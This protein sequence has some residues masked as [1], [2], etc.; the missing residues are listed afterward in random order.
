MNHLWS[1]WMAALRRRTRGTRST[2]FVAVAL[3]A[4][5]A[6]ASA[7]RAAGDDPA[8]LPCSQIGPLGL[9]KQTNIR[10]GL[11]LISCGLAA[12]GSSRAAG[13]SAPQ[14]PRSPLQLG[15]SDV[16]VVTGVEPYPH[17]TQAGDQTWANGSTVVAAYN[18]TNTASSNYSGVSYSTDGGASFT[19]I[20]PS[21]FA[22]GHGTNFGVPSVVFDKKLGTW[23]AGFLATGCG[24]QGLGLW[25]SPDGITWS[26]GACAH[27]GTQDD[28]P[29]MWVDNTPASPFY[30]RIYLTYNDFNVA[31]GALFATHSD[32][33][34]TWTAPF[35]VSAGFVRNVGVSVAEDGT[36]LVAAM[37]EGGGGFAARRNIDYRSTDG[38]VTF[39]GQISMGVPFA[40]A[41]DSVCPTNSYFTRFDPVWRTMGWGDLAAGANT[42]VVYSYVVHGA[43]SDGGDIYVVRST[44]DGQTWGPPVR[45]DGDASLHAQWMPTA[46]GAGSNFF[47]TWYDRRDTTDA[48][49]Y[50]RWGSMSTDGGATWGAPQRI[51]DVLIP[52]PLQVDPSANSCY[53]GD[54]NRDVYDNGVFYDAWTDGRIAISGQNQMD[55]FADGVAG[56]TL[57]E[58]FEAGSLRTFDPTSTPSTGPAWSWV[59]TASHS[60]SHSAFAPDISSVSDQRLTLLSGIAIPA[61]ATSSTLTFWHKFGF[62][63][64]GANCFDGGVLEASTDDGATWQDAGPNIT[65]D[66]Y[67]GTV[68]SSF[69]NPLAG[70]AAWC[71]NPN[72]KSFTQ[73]T[74]NLLPYKPQTVLLRFREGTDSSVAS[75]GWWVDDV[76]IAVPTAVEVAR[77][78]AA[79]TRGGALVR[80]R[81]G[82][83]ANTAGFDLYRG[84][85]KVNPSLIVAKHPG[86]TRGAKYRF[87]DRGARPGGSYTYR[88]QVVHLDGT[89]SPAGSTSLPAGR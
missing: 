89:R 76:G 32:D 15:G 77:L 87:L 66:G 48:T 14:A 41:G 33:G 47:V 68:S 86:Q 13:P 79:P 24:G 22:T 20:L 45:I 50:E 12:G 23:F 57:P 31:G 26:V 21:P 46:S 69:G 88:L 17:V 71:Q 40:A 44:D 5:L 36:V 61:S 38:G 1:I 49:N 25:T 67:N 3:V 9:E 85:T 10:A 27:S 82:S 34:A 60:S 70:R 58:D 19:R 18:D 42:T 8:P 63:G 29:S 64:S 80:W 28:R 35:G 72:G 52:Q 11:T 6:P 84:A 73:V 83:E 37:N 78:N 39:G 74:V 56:P 7:L 59:S 4:I 62:E 75:G 30:G 53:A 2:V 51:S 55:V 16:D 81:T 65:A 54:Y 43:T